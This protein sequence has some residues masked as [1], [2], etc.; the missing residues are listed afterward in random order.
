MERSQCTSVCLG[1][2]RRL[3]EGKLRSRKVRLG[4]WVR[5]EKENL[6]GKKAVGTHT[7]I[8]IKDTQTR[9]V[10][11]L[12]PEE[13]TTK[14]RQRCEKKSP[15]IRTL[16]KCH[17]L[18][19]EDTH[20]EKKKFGKFWTR[21]EIEGKTTDMRINHTLRIFCTESCERQTKRKSPFESSKTNEEINAK[22][23]ICQRLNGK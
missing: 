22:K 13:D 17:F 6:K 18:A 15:N 23:S 2:R 21:Q 9:I 8:G 3:R 16:L 12:K 7:H 1:P 14:S 4:R 19:I 11:R 20:I 5:A 10:K